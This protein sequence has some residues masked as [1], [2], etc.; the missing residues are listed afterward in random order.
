MIELYLLIIAILLVSILICLYVYG[1]KMTI[2]HIEE[3]RELRATIEEIESIHA[4][5]IFALKRKYER[6]G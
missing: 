2:K 4:R 6:E 3:I 5:N 1:Y